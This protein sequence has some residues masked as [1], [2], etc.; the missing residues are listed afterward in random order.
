MLL[1]IRKTTFLYSKLSV[2]PFLKKSTRCRNNLQQLKTKKMK[3]KLLSAVAIFLIF[4]ANAQ[5]LNQNAGFTN[6]TLGFYEMSIVNKNTAWA[7]CY[8]GKA[9][10]NNGRFILDFTRTIDGGSTWV[11]GKMG[12]DQSLQFSNIS[13]VSGKEAWVAMNKRFITGGGLYHT[14][15]AGITWAQSNAGKIFDE[16][17]FPDF[18]YFK[19]HKIGIAVGDPN[20]GYFEIYITIGGGKNWKRVPRTHIPP[21]LANEYGWISGYAAV[22]N[23]I[24]FGTSLGRM[25]KSTNFGITWTV[26]TVDPT[27]NGVYEI[28]FNDDK[29]HGVTHVRNNFGQTFLFSTTDGGVTW[30]NLGQPANWKSSRIT[31]VPGTNAFVS[32]SVISSNQGSAVS[33]D[34]GATWT[35]IEHTAPKAV[36]RFLD[37]ETGWAGGYF[38]TGP[39][40]SGGIYKSQIDFQRPS[41]QHD[42]GKV[43]GNKLVE[44]NG[45]DLVKVYPIPANDVINIF[46]Q[47]A[48]V[49]TPSV[50]SILS[51]DGK[52]IESRKS[53]GSKLIQLDISKLTSGPYMLRIKTK[54]QTIN[55]AISIAK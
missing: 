45:I 31:V 26:N 8:D 27:G 5:W 34:N 9:G 25:Y 32:T 36:A 55:K 24:W 40:F 4:T 54:T 41:S 33:Y 11:P 53:G 22:G 37:A 30:T 18:V 15:D 28:A 2:C 44:K 3:K 52:V 1:F 10:L 39:P 21:P 19:N 43:T 14:T 38:I 17:S 50:I 29:L 23:T 46:F 16:N 7:V 6:D 48:L 13:A 20:G 35:E 12:N 51:M 49:N 42:S 47:D